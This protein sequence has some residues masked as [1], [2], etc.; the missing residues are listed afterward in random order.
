[1]IIDDDNVFLREMTKVI[2]WPRAPC[3]GDLAWE[4]LPGPRPTAGQRWGEICIYLF[5]R[6]QIYVSSLNFPIPPACWPSAGV[7]VPRQHLLGK[8]SSAYVGEKYAA[9][10]KNIQHWQ[11]I[12]SIGTDICSIGQKYAAL[13]T[14]MR[15][16]QARTAAA[17]KAE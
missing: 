12:F 13:A 4:I 17:E 3:L 11:Q 8:A 10:A 7:H 16:G 14:N 9:S 5:G 1:M 2:N 6:S 15:N